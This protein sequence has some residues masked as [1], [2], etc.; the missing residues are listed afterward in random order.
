MITP[1]QLT[2]IHEDYER[3]VKF[4]P[5]DVSFETYVREQEMKV[6]AEKYDEY[7]SGLGSGDAETSDRE[8]PTETH[9]PVLAR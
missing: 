5:F 1:E 7:C 4:R 9:R 6:K 8:G 2:A 3:W